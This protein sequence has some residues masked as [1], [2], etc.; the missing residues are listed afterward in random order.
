MNRSKSVESL[1]GVGDIDRR[2]RLAS[3]ASKT[4]FVTLDESQL[5]VID[6]RKFVTD[7][8]V[9][10][11]P[12]VRFTLGSLSSCDASSTDFDS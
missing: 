6:S 5:S 10:M 3:V 1:D 11:Q 12:Y 4:A 2:A 7:D 9:S 8:N